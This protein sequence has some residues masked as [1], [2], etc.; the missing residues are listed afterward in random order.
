MCNSS[1]RISNPRDLLKHNVEI[2]FV[3]LFIFFS[4]MSAILH[5]T[6][7]HWPAFCTEF[8]LLTL[9]FCPTHFL[10]LFLCRAPVLKV[11]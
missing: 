4:L 5:E 11:S 2:N 10:R 6:Y 1:Q 8:N 7:D 3:F 9:F